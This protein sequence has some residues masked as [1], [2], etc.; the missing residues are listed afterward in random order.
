MLRATVARLLAPRQTDCG[1]TQVPLVGSANRLE[2]AAAKLLEFPTHSF[3]AAA[4]TSEG[5]SLYILA[6]LVFHMGGLSAP[7]G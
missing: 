2:D 6:R 7:S 1:P 5:C 4:P 3:M